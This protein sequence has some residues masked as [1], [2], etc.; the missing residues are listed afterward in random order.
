MLRLISIQH[1]ANYFRP[2]SMIV[3]ARRDK[4]CNLSAT[5]RTKSDNNL[6]RLISIVSDQCHQAC[7]Q[8]LS[9]R[10]GVRP[11]AGG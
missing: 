4:S 7:L 10:F 3:A 6:I 8:N 2:M 9:E 5:H 1:R 11:L